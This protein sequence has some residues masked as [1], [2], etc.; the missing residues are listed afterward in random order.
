MSTIPGTI[1]GLG[2]D[3]AELWLDLE[4]TVE[5]LSGGPEVAEDEFLRFQER[6]SV[7]ELNA[8][9]L[10]KLE[11]SWSSFSFLAETTEKLSR[12]ARE[13]DLR[14]AEVYWHRILSN[15]SDLYF[16][17]PDGT[18]LE[19]SLVPRHIEER[20]S[21]LLSEIKARTPVHLHGELEE[22]PI[23]SELIEVCTLE[24]LSW[25]SKHP[26]D[27]YRVHPGTFERIVAEI[28]ESEGFEVEVISSWNQADGGVDLI[29]AKKISSAERIRLA[30]QCKRHKATKRVT[31]EPVRSLHG[32]LDRFQAD[33]GVVATTSHFSGPAVQETRRYYWR[34]SLRDHDSIIRSLRELGGYTL[35]DTGLWL[36][37][38]SS[39]LP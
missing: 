1:V 20:V 12:A 2:K 37:E 9:E 10:L 6:V 26:K 32:V 8:S 23:V 5:S 33:R 39:S 7:D 13:H 29:A 24:L 34:V 35:S 15:T 3:L 31:A 4:M 16:P 21:G 28:F 17:S 19:G 14:L 22:S 38:F 27:L 18:I 11:E 25:L 30:I 36:P